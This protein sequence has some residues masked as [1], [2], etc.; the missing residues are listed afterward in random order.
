ML[1]PGCI[2]ASCRDTSLQ[3]IK[4]RRH[5]HRRRRR[6][7]LLP[8]EVDILE[9]IIS[10]LFK[11]F[12]SL[13]KK[14][15]ELCLPPHL[16]LVT[17][18]DRVTPRDLRCPHRR[19]LLP[20]PPPPHCLRSCCIAAAPFCHAVP[21]SRNT[22][23]SQCVSTNIGPEVRFPHFSTPP[24]DIRVQASACLASSSPGMSKTRCRR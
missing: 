4:L 11:I 10:S 15:S 8:P 3:S 16:W 9:L 2:F 12:K 1:K 22:V 20:P 13:L 17:Q 23:I 14:A 7:S 18:L 6:V 24:P 5:R 19:P 21:V